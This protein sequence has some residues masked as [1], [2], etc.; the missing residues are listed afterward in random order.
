[1]SLFEVEFTVRAVV[2]ADDS[3]HA[4]SVAMDERREIFSDTSIG[5]VDVCREIR[6]VSHLPDGWDVACLPYGGDGNTRIG[7]ILAEIPSVPERD[8]KTIDMFAEVRP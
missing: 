1:M 3:T 4:Y 7:E 6:E 2:Q 8:T 5:D